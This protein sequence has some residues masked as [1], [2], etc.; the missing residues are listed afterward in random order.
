MISSVA[1]APP[2]QISQER[3]SLGLGRAL[4]MARFFFEQAKPSNTRSWKIIELETDF[5]TSVAGDVQL[6]SVEGTAQIDL[7]FHPREP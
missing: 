4:R 1:G 5:A 7:T 3:L 2:L 6:V